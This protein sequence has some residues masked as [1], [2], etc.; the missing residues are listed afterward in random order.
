MRK[1]FKMYKFRSMCVDAE[2]KLETLLQHN[3]V[4]GAMF[5]MKR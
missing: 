1:N 4:E 5:K 3:E 2:E